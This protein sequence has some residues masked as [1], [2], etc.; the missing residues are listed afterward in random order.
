MTN[1][2]DKFRN[3]YRVPSA[4]AA[5]HEYDDGIY[6]ITICTAGMTHY[7]GEISDGVMHLSEIG[8]IANDCFTRMSV[9]YPYAEI[10][11]FVIMPNHIHAIV[12]INGGDNV[13]GRDAINRVSTTTTI[14]SSSST[15]TISRNPMIH[16]SL[17]TVIRG[18]KARIS[19]VAH[20]NGI[21]FGW[22]TRFYDHIIRTHAEMNRIA[23]YIENNVAKWD[24]DKLNKTE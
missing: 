11:L 2:M 18:V 7:L 22:Q 13:N 10:P 16:K 15:G 5:W 9:Y 1:N 19:R 23:E 17:G 8:N 20:Q 14:T 3:K 4:R 21:S 24:L 12:V 6:F